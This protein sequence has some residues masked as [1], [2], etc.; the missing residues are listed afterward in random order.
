MTP[1]KSRP[2]PATSKRSPT[3]QPTATTPSKRSPTPQPTVRTT[4]VTSPAGPQLVS[5]PSTVGDTVAQ[6][7]QILEAAGFRVNVKRFG[8]TNKVWDYS[9]VGRHPPGTTVTLDVGVF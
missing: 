1:G 5:V 2:S 9:P 6:A 7:T 8:A 3:P 4:I